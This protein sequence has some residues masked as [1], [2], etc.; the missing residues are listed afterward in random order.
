MDHARA[1]GKKKHA[2]LQ[3]EQ[4]NANTGNEGTAFEGT[5][6]QGDTA[7][8]EDEGEELGNAGHGR[9]ERQDLGASEKQYG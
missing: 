9:D 7:H 1:I 4:E 5:D 3:A 2:K 6:H 8:H